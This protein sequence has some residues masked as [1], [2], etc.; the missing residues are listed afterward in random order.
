[1]KETLAISDHSMW[2]THLRDVRFM[3]LRGSLVAPSSFRATA[4]RCVHLQPNA[5]LDGQVNVEKSFSWN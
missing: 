5:S 2:K 3:D 1:M 4:V